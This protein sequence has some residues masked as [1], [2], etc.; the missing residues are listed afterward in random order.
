[1]LLGP[2][3]AACAPFSGETL[4][5][6][7]PLTEKSLSGDS[8]QPEAIKPIPELLE[9]PTTPPET[10]YSFWPWKEGEAAK[11][12]PVKPYKLPTLSG[13][14]LDYHDK[15]APL[16]KAPAID[17]EAV[18]DY[19]LACYPEKSQWNLDVNLRAQLASTPDSILSSDGTS[20]TELGSSYVAIVANMPL[21]SI[22]EL[23]RERERE[24]ARRQEVAGIVSD[25]IAAIASRNHAIRELALYRSLEARSSLRVQQ[26]ISESTEQVK[27][28]EKVAASHET[29]IKQEA[30]IMDT[31][32]KL[33]GMCD[34]ANADTLNTWL[35]QV[36]AVPR[37]EPAP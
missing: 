9:N 31:R 12:P 1:V 37:R 4:P 34:P 15:P 36:S 10:G 5:E 23:N 16:V 29:L 14:N 2:I 32:L 8:A 30:K 28:L 19:V 21:Y 27:F 24:H 3:N 17:A 7:L 11:P 13:D 18:Y 20:T 26:G 33:S 35:K 6:P 25:F 22:T